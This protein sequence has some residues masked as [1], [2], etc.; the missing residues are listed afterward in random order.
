ME[1]KTAIM[2]RVLLNRYHTRDIDSVLKALT[3]E[4]AKEVLTYDVKSSDIAPVFVQP[5]E[6]IQRIHYSW[7]VPIF[8]KWAPDFQKLILS[9]LPESHRS[10]LRDLLKP[11]TA[12]S[13]PAPP[14]RSYLQELLIKQLWPSEILPVEY[15]PTK[16]LSVLAKATKNELVDL[17][18]IL[19]MF[20][21]AEEVRQIVDKNTLR[22]IYRCLSLKKRKYLRF[23]LQQPEKL[24]MS[25]RMRLNNW[26]GTSEKL[27]KM[28]HRRG[29]VRFAFAL[30]GKERDLTW[31]LARTVDRGRG[32]ILERY[33]SENPIQDVTS[34]LE[35]QVISANNFLKHQDEN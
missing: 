35:Q 5:E 20:D 26:D 33:Y 19:G 24:K 2:M 7:L 11:K 10:K 8:K 6:L 1:R 34:I 16:P 31:H 14:A 25:D 12:L 3:E 13:S 30:S 27:L 17:F 28:I 22:N 4:E 29:I 21:L 15:L 9:A 23:C 32:E 18:D